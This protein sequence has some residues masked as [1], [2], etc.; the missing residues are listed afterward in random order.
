M[1]YGELLD[2]ARP[3][4]GRATCCD[5]LEGLLPGAAENGTSW[6]GHHL[7]LSSWRRQQ[8]DGRVLLAGDAAGLIN[9]MTGEG[10]YYAVAT[11][12]L[13]GRSAAQALVVET[14]W[15]PVRS[16]GPPYAPCS[17]GISC[18]PRS[19]LGSSDCRRS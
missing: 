13:A 16:A 3:A 18:T 7:P 11:G 14:A 12:V 17:V 15:V 19:R 8:P 4:P 5:R 1:G 2:P 10:I 9:P 6:R